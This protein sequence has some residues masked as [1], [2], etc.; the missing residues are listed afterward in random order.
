[1]GRLIKKKYYDEA[2]EQNEKLLEL[3]R[4]QDSIIKDLKLQVEKAGNIINMQQSLIEQYREEN[5]ELK[6]APLKSVQDL[7]NHI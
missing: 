5:L 2:M 6:K 1:M 3:C 4:K 7:I